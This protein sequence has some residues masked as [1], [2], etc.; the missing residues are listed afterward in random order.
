MADS[1]DHHALKPGFRLREWV[2]DGVLGAGGF[3][4]V[5]KGTGV[6]FAEAVAIKEYFPT[7]LA[8]RLQDTSISPSSKSNEDVFRYGLE[9]FIQEAQILWSLSR[10]NRHPNLLGV[11][12]L[13]EERSRFSPP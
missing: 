3:A 2:V 1:Y 8:V 12:G 9:K 13:F 10:P 4:I 11:R 5:Y 6:Y 7:E